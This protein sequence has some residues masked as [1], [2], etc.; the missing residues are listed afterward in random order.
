MVWSLSIKL[1]MLGLMLV[2]VWWMGPWALD[3][4]R[5]ESFQPLHPALVG[6]PNPHTKNG[7]ININVG[8]LQELETLPGIGTVLAQRILDYRKHH[9]AFSSIDDLQNIHGIG[10]VRMARLRSLITI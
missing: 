1:M 10:K 7:I 8:T 2:G 9:G 3:P 6:A 5:G 4:S